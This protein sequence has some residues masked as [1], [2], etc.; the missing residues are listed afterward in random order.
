MLRLHTFGGLWISDSSQE[1]VGPSLGRKPLALLALLA[2]SGGRTMSRDRVLGLLWP[3]K[4]QEHARNALNQAVFLVRR[5]LGPTVLVLHRHELALDTTVCTSDVWDFVTAM[6]Q[7]SF[8]R[9]VQLYEGAFLDGFYVPDAGE[10]ERWAE[11]ERVILRQ[12]YAHALEQLASAADSHAAAAWLQKAATDDP[13]SARITL[14]LMRALQAS[15]DSAAAIRV[16]DAHEA[17]VRTELGADVDPQ[18]RALASELRVLGAGD[19]I[20]QRTPVR[21]DVEP[22]TRHDADDAPV[23]PTTPSDARSDRVSPT[24]R[25]ASRLV[26]PALAA[27]LIAVSLF[28]VA[29]TPRGDAETDGAHRRRV[30]VTAFENRS[31]DTTLDQLGELASDWVSQGLAQTGMADVAPPQLTFWA[32]TTHTSTLGTPITPADLAR[33]AG[34][35]LVVSGR[36]YRVGDTLVVNA[37][38]DDLRRRTT[39]VMPPITAPATKP[40]LAVETLRQRV[41]GT[42]A[43]RVDASYERW[44][45]YASKPATFDAYL[46]YARGLDRFLKGDLDTAVID[47]TAAAALDTGFTVPLLWS[48][49]AFENSGADRAADSVAQLLE[50]KRPSL[51][52]WDR[53][54]LDYLRVDPRNAAEAQYEAARR[55]V[56]LAPGSEWVYKRS[57]AALQTNRPREAIAVLSDLDPTRGWM[58]RWGSYWDVMTLAHHRLHEYDQEL[59]DVRRH[60]AVS[61]NDDG[62]QREA[63]SPLAA[64]GRIASLDSVLDAVVTG[65]S[66][67]DFDERVFAFRM[68]V[69]ELRTHGHLDA[70]RRVADRFSAWLDQLPASDRYSCTAYWGR[71]TAAYYTERFAESLRITREWTRRCPTDGGN[72]VSMA[73]AAASLGDRSLAD[74]ALRAIDP[75]AAGAEALQM[76]EVYKLFAAARVAALFGERERAV[77]LLANALRR[78]GIVYNNL[79]YELPLERLHSYA[80]YEELV[81]IRG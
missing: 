52:P 33:R 59:A 41:M 8:E 27:G 1:R 3:E 54:L 29:H 14:A 16:A 77:A 19:T 35:D 36:Y 58:R 67:A 50:T 43:A 45:T 28:A 2:R 23:E 51:A 17:R 63:I 20:S 74:S 9:A 31:G 48:V 69:I 10:F 53:A 47:F 44:A 11:R 26:A 21:N 30:L 39:D 73:L 49:F 71:F 6:T 57:L 5:T 18:V 15:G 46:R 65:Q 38:L 56:E 22:R 7:R 70:G 42:L 80:P 37:T 24:R 34:A 62:I 60:A 81:K 76:T 25:R 32:P 68:A 78:D 4:D 55:L 12:Q 75:R 13:L 40:L 66:P 64:L 61:P 79:E 72:F